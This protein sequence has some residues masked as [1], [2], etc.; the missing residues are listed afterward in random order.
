MAPFSI[1]HSAER[2]N[3]PTNAALF[4][5]LWYLLGLGLGESDLTCVPSA[6]PK[7]GF[8]PDGNPWALALGPEIFLPLVKE[9]EGRSPVVCGE[10]QE[11][12]YNRSSLS[13]NIF[14]LQKQSSHMLQLTHMDIIVFICGD[15]SKNGILYTCL[16]I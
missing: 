6:L 7:Q 11:Q 14:H 9:Q 3:S 8:C 12:I 13:N 16:C 2:P 10:R 5:V 15:S 4:H 1:P